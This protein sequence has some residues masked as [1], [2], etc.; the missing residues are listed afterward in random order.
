MSKNVE[1]L[2]FQKDVI[3]ALGQKVGD[4]MDLEGVASHNTANHIFGRRVPA[5]QRLVFVFDWR[6]VRTNEKPERYF[7]AWPSSE[8][9]LWQFVGSDVSH[10]QHGPSMCQF[11][12]T[13]QEVKQVRLQNTVLCHKRKTAKLVEPQILLKTTLFYSQDTKSRNISKKVKTRGIFFF[14]WDWCLKSNLLWK[15]CTG[16]RRVLSTSLILV[17]ATSWERRAE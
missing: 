11:T 17:T 10:V 5:L 3:S 4:G 9:G 6:V 8:G 2:S 7:M 12:R 15:M 14:N 1:L 16:S 13:R